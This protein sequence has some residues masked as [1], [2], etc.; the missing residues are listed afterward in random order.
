MGVAEGE[1]ITPVDLPPRVRAAG[2]ATGG[3]GAAAAPA[4]AEAPSRAPRY[5]G[6]FKSRMERFEGETLLEVL[7]EA[8]DNQRAAARILDMPLRTLQYKLRE[9]GIKRKVGL[10]LDDEDE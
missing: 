8:N 1:T 2:A 5:T 6:S 9:L 7:G 3:S 10:G 4:A